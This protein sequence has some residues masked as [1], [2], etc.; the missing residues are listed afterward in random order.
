MSDLVARGWAVV[1]GGEIARASE[2]PESSLLIYAQRWPAREHAQDLNYYRDV[3][4]YFVARRVEIRVC[5][6][7]SK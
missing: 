6:R 3:A 1:G 2:S 5:S 7:T 4:G